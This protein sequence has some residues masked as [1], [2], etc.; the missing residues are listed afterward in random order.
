M[1]ISSL[2]SLLTHAL[3]P[4]KWHFPFFKYILFFHYQIYRHYTLESRK[5]AQFHKGTRSPPSRLDP[6]FPSSRQ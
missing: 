1:K 2:N 4:S 3:K 5:S 6:R